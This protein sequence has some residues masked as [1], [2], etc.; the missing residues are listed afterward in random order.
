MTSDSSRSNDSDQS[1]DSDQSFDSDQL[2]DL[3]QSL[4]LDKKVYLNKSA[5]SVDSFEPK[6]DSL[7]KPFKYRTLDTY[8]RTLLRMKAS[9]E[10][11]KNRLENFRNKQKPK[12]IKKIDRNAL[13]AGT[14]Y[15]SMVRV[16]KP[17]ST[18]ITPYAFGSST[19][20]P[21]VLTSHEN[22]TNC[23]YQCKPKEPMKP[24]KPMKSMKPK[25]PTKPIDN[26]EAYRQLRNMCKPKKMALPKPTDRMEMAKVLKTIRRKPP[27]PQS[28]K[29]TVKAKANESS[30]KPRWNTVVKPRSPFK[31]ISYI[32]PSSLEIEWTERQKK[33][34]KA[35]KVK[36]HTRFDGSSRVVDPKTQEDNIQM[37]KR[38][39]NVKS[40][41]S[42]LNRYI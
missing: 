25:K 41:L 22:T 13:R 34:I 16:Q 32:P 36:L 18:G 27:T 17:K 2:F 38:I 21:K 11:H 24:M 10:N 3:D 1:I 30:E 5:N 7:T 26:D 20:I 19:K 8:E 33:T 39:L 29:H 15:L 12:T 42:K 23:K 4:D 6:I 40:S 31:P 14:S 9:V 35:Y 37:I 28:V